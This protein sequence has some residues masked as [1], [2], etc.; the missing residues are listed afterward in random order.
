MSEPTGYDKE[1]VVIYEAVSRRQD[2]LGMIRGL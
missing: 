1:S 2:C